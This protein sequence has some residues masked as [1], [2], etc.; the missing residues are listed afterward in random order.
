MANNVDSDYSWSSLKPMPTKR[1]FS[2]AVGVG[3]ELYILGKSSCND[4]IILSCLSVRT[5]SWLRSVL[6]SQ[7]L[8]C[9]SCFV[10]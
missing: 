6:S 9:G 8:A 1:V 5:L 3:S 7:G 4:Y 2:T 10:F